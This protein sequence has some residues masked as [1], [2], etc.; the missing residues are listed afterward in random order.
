[1]TGLPGSAAPQRL[2]SLH[3][4]LARSSMRGHWEALGGELPELRPWVWRWSEIMS[5]LEE[6]GRLVALGKADDVNDRRTLWLVNP[7]LIDQALGS[8]STARTFLMAVQMVKPGE[9]GETHRHT[10]NALRFIVQST[11][12]Y[13]T[14]DGEQM[15]ME[16][17]DLLLQPNWAWHGHI[18][19][20][21]EPAIWLDVLDAPLNALMG[22]HFKDVWGEGPTQPVT[23]S[24][25]YSRQRFGVVRPRT[26]VAGNQTVPYVYKWQDTLRALEEMDAS[27]EVDPHEGIAV[28]YTNPLT[29][30]PTFPTLACQMQLLRPGQET[31]PQR[32]VGSTMYH[33]VRGRGTTTVG[34]GE[35]E[36]GELRTPSRA[37]SPEI[38][39]WGERDCFFVPSWRWY[40]FRNRSDK[41]PAILF[42]V[43]DRP[44]L[45][46]FGWYREQRG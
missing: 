22:A 43:S 44:A 38:L 17:G 12:A 25:G 20:T 42:S 16:P 28:E 13:T 6:A 45:T 26:V 14:S 11:G 40:H 29:G 18:N 3:E 10:Q 46:A 36:E 35:F 1:M 24:D 15:V 5:F 31:L 37:S 34:Q 8:R 33:V 30:G 21:S 9:V 32:R 7:A 23:K 19:E 41:E 2:Q 27:G 39:E 4:R